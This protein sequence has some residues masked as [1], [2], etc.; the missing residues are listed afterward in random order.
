MMFLF[1]AF[2]IQKGMEKCIDGKLENWKVGM[3]GNWGIG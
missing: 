3:M 2:N 1:E